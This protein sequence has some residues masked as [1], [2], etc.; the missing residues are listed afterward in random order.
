M[1][2][3]LSFSDPIGLSQMLVD[4]SQI[5]SVYTEATTVLFPYWTWLIHSSC[6]DRELARAAG[7][8][9]LNQP[10]RYCK[11]EKKE[12][13]QNLTSLGEELWRQVKSSRRRSCLDVVLT[14]PGKITS[15]RFAAPFTT[16]ISSN[17]PASQGWGL[18][19]C[20]HSST[21]Y[22]FPYQGEMP[23]SRC[24]FLPDSCLKG[25]LQVLIRLIA[26]ILKHTFL[27][28]F[29]IERNI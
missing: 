24:C 23:L 20:I 8:L 29:H 2:L 4:L 16:E 18:A 12:G 15:G 6:Q 13:S 27:V 17:G 5:L 14:S 21:L 3:F 9:P 28:S 1:N 7:P 10:W 22:T 26:Q 25:V 19:S 11:D